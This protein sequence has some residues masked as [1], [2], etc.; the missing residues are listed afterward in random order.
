MQSR[1]FA[2][3]GMNNSNFSV[4]D[5]QTSLDFALPHTKKNEKV[6]TIPFRNISNVG[7][8]GSINSS[9]E[10]MAKWVQLQLSDGKKLIKKERLQEMHLIATAVQFPFFSSPAESPYV[11]GYGLGWM[12]GFYK[13]HY[14]VTHSGAID[15]FIS[16]VVLFPN[17][18]IGVVVLTNA[19]SH[20]L[21]SAF[22]ALG[23]ADLAMG[24]REEDWLR[25]VE[26]K[27]KAMKAALQ[28]DMPSI[29]SVPLRPLQHY[30]GEFENAG[31]GVILVKL[32]GKDLVAFYNE[33]PMTLHHKCYDHFITT[34]K[35]TAEQKLASSFINNPSG[36]ISEFHIAL[37][38]TCQPIVFKRKASNEL[39]TEDYLKKFIGVFEAQ[40]VSVEFS[41]TNMHLTAN[42]PGQPAY[43]LIPEK[44]FVFSI[45]GLSGFSTKFVSDVQ[46][47]IGEAQLIQ[48][49]GTFSLKAK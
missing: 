6:E 41:F 35:L 46:G 14:L 15:G 37:E 38:P 34:M 32:E 18:K 23:I 44:P 39:L 33:I 24:N 12:T 28:M 26:E 5:S 48:P 25:L 40:G 7:P 47:K 22:A 8:A 49:N 30:I 9:V 27:E 43:Q 4:V 10:D 45:K 1:I 2:P 3:L 19:D 31:Y 20:S 11:F 21:F 29:E 13:G 42:I 36:E 17:E 16:T